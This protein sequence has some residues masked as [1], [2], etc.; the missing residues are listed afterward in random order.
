MTPA[1]PKVSRLP[2][3]NL[4]MNAIEHHAKFVRLG[5]LDP[6]P[7]DAGAQ[8]VRRGTQLVHDNT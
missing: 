6:E 8:V 7:R 4:L 5:S 2:I 3:V 1:N